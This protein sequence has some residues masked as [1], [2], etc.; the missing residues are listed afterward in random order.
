MD[1]QY[2]NVLRTGARNTLRA[3]AAGAGIPPQPPTP[4]MGP[5]QPPLEPLGPVRNPN[6]AKGIQSAES[7][8][9]GERLRTQ[10]MGPQRPAGWTPPP[11]GAAPVGAAPTSVPPT[12]TAPA[13]VTAAG[14]AAAGAGAGAGASLRQRAL[15]GAGRAGALATRLAPAAAAAQVVNHFNDYKINDPETD[16]SA[17]GSWNALRNGDWG[18]LRRSLG[19]GALEAGMDLGSAV[20]NIADFV[21]PGHN[22]AST[23]YDRWLRDQFGDQLRGPTVGPAPAPSAAA[24]PKPA[25][26]TAAAPA[27]PPKPPTLPVDQRN[28][29]WTNEAVAARNPSGQVRVTMGEDGVPTFSGNNVSGAVSYKDDK[30][31]I[32][33]KGWVGDSWGGGMNVISMPKGEG[34]RDDGV[35]LNQG[36]GSIGGATLSSAAAERA[37][38]T[39]PVGRMTALEMSRLPPDTRHAL[40]VQAARNQ[41]DMDRAQLQADTQRYGTD[42][43]AASSRFNTNTNAETLRRGQNMDL[44]GRLLPKQWD[45]AMQQR[46]RAMMGQLYKDSGGNYAEAAKRAAAFGMDDVAKSFRDAA[47]DEG[48]FSDEQLAGVRGLFKDQFSTTGADGKVVARPDLEAA[49]TEQVMKMTGGRFSS[50][51]AEQRNALM[52]K[53]VADVK[54]LG[55]ANSLRGGGF[56]EFVGLDSKPP[57]FSQLPS[58]AED[59]GSTLRQADLL[60]RLSPLNPL[61]GGD[62]VQETQDGRQ[63]R[64]R[65]DNVDQA[66]LR[67]M[68]NNGAKLK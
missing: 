7:L 42:V 39:G 2:P 34:L 3:E 59:R 43:S 65:G 37:G 38:M 21:T 23:K 16:S 24:M 60:E 48:K 67:E 58:A 46:K 49:A 56:K 47:G 17:A 64:Y 45:M 28:D 18:G 22:T 57:A 19:K 30:G 26:P 32:P 61:R 9:Q 44:E 1:S 10:S 5:G 36:A 27:A 15:Y 68:Q 20:A 50:L 31:I 41:G 33:G 35:P 66:R 25:A 62:W 55:D 63:F 29:D 54:L 14:G 40:R 12:G 51:P 6:V 8:K 4:R 13:S 53:A 52:S 11:A